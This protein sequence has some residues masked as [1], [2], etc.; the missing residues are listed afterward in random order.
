V[1]NVW[2]LA[3][4]AVEPQF[5]VRLT[6]SLTPM[7]LAP[8][9]LAPSGFLYIV[10]RGLVICGGDLLT[11]GSTW[12]EDVILTPIMPGLCVPMH[13]KAINHTEVYLISWDVLDEALSEFPLSAEHV[14]RC[15]LRL[16]MRR[17]IIRAAAAARRLRT[18]DVY[19]LTEEDMQGVQGAGRS[20]TKREYTGRGAAKTGTELGRGK[21]LKRMMMQSTQVSQ[22]EASLQTHLI[23]ARRGSGGSCQ[24]SATMGSGSLGLAAAAGSG[25]VPSSPASSTMSLLASPTMAPAHAEPRASAKG[26]PKRT[27]KWIP[28]DWAPTIPCASASPAVGWECRPTP[29]SPQLFAPAKRVALQD[30]DSSYLLKSDDDSSVEGDTAIGDA[31]TTTRSSFLNGAP[32]ATGAAPH[33]YV[34]SSTSMDALAMAVAR[35]SSAVSLL[36]SDMVSLRAEVQPMRTIISELAEIKRLL[37]LNQSRA[38]RRDERHTARTG[39]SD[40]PVLM[41]ALGA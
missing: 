39:G 23:N 36:A 15:A 25:A 38:E 31:S 16:A 28:P 14:R 27:C 20:P 24:L 40:H 13:A 11:S 21:T 17:Q 22:A 33:F 10:Y 32:M 3:N 1:R 34:E 4:E 2:F 37:S 9:E 8:F 26:G 7:V 18:H 30:S 5:I 29:P 6:L 12:G 41:Q 35:Q 19:S